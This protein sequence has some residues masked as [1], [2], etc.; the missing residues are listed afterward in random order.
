MRTKILNEQKSNPEEY[1]LREYVT[2]LKGK[3]M[4]AEGFFRLCDCTYSKSITIDVFKSKIKEIG[5]KLTETQVRRLA[6]IFDED[7]EGS[8]SYEEYQN[9]LEAFKLSAE[10]H[11]NCNT[12]SR[13]YRPF[14]VRTMEYLMQVIAKNSMTPAQLYDTCNKD[15]SEYIELDELKDVISE[16]HPII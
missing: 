12:N 7:M 8:I 13:H 3:K 1:A 4:T 15:G 11:I 10:S 5:L 14:A 6:L 9:A 16:I 2:Q